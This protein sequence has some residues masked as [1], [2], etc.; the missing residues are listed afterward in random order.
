MHVV[1]YNP[2]G[3]KV[4]DA[5]LKADDFGGV[6]GEWA[7]PEDATLGQYTIQT[8]EIGGG[9][10]FRIEEYKKPEFQVTVDAPSEPV[11][12]RREDHRQDSGQVLLRLARR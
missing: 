1:I 4:V 8:P 12:A 7:I 5:N 9:G 2:K 3:D 6:A 10:H 11:R